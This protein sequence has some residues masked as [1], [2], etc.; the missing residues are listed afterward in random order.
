MNH[1]APSFFLGMDVKRIM[2]GDRDG[3]TNW[4]IKEDGEEDSNDSSS[5][6]LNSM[7]SMCSSSSSELSEDASSSTSS[8]HSNGPLF[9]LSDLMSHLPMK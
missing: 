3:N 7:D 1:K 5:I 8:T 4:V 9:E 2:G 6:G